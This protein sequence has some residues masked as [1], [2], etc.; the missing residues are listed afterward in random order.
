M[1]AKKNRVRI[2]SELAA[3]VLFAADRACCV[4]RAKGK[5]IQIHHIDDDPSN[6]KFTNLA[7]L[8]LDCHDLT[9]IKGG[10]GRKLDADQVRLYRDHWIGTVAESRRSSA[11][12]IS[13]LEDRELELR[14]ATSVAEINLEKEDWADLALHYAGIGNV[15][16]RDKYTEKAIASGV[17]DEMHC[18]LREEQ[19]M[20]ERIPAD[21]IQREIRRLSEGPHA[22]QAQLARLL[23]TL[24]RTQDAVRAYVN[25]II[26]D[27]DDQRPF[28]AAFYLKE[29]VQSGLVE[30]LFIEALKEAREKGDLWWEIRALEELGWHDEL[31]S[32]VRSRRGEIEEKGDPFQLRVLYRYEGDR[33]AYAD[34][35]EL[36]ERAQQTVTDEDG[37]SYTVYRFDSDDDSDA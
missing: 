7:V 34:V 1:P 3:Q 9:Q 5:P 21:V 27:L 17:S 33:E 16:L 35:V 13:D 18:L 12:E 29:I 26:E 36:I 30:G 25:G 19:G 10:F 11:P 32:V 22:S 28:A 4:C 24:G 23:R 37:T 2:P 8:C 15:E 6:N 31:R 14:L 20:P